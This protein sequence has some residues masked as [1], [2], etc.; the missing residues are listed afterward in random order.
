LVNG[1][2]SPILIVNFLLHLIIYNSVF[3]PDISLYYIYIF[4][5]YNL[6]WSEVARLCP[7]LCNLMD[8][9]LP[10][11]SV[12]G[13]FQTRVLEWVAISSSSYNLKFYLIY[14]II[15]ILVSYLR[16]LPRWLSGTESSCQCSRCSNCRF[17]PWVRKIPWRRKWQ[18]AS[19]FLPE[20]S[21]G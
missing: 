17:D 19:V 16:G 11:S 4:L 20:K 3:L 5:C 9:S 8:C 7:T 6:K 2:L 14:H 13:I 18:P 21:H 15:Y 1:K 10:R 12:H